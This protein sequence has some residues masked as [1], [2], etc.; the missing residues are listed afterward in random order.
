MGTAASQAVVLAA[1]GVV[2]ADEVPVVVEHGAAGAA[3]FR[4]REIAENPVV[5]LEH[6]VVLERELRLFQALGWPMT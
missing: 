6:D 3:G 5:V 4:G 2:Q 1:G